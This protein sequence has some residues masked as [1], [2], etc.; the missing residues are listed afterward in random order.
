MH[1]LCAHA[2]PNGF[3]DPEA[4]ERWMERVLKSIDNIAL[5]GEKACMIC[6]V[7]GP[8][9]APKSRGAYFTLIAS[10]GDAMAELVAMTKACIE[11]A[12]SKRAWRIVWASATGVDF[13]PLAVKFGASPISPDYGLE[14]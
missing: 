5:R 14:L 3:Y 4:S 1:G 6:S 13:G 2:Y 11:W 9:Y 10:F 8:P 12:R 7:F